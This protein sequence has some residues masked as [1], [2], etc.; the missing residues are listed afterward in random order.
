MTK[1]FNARHASRDV[2]RTSSCTTRGMYMHARTGRKR[3]RESHEPRPKSTAC[4]AVRR[5]L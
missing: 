2:W 5:V 4:R 3:E 1:D